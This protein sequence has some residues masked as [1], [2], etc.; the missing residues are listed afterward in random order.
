ML[1]THGWLNI[2]RYT[3]S[4]IPM[5]SQYYKVGTMVGQRTNVTWDILRQSAHKVS[6]GRI[7]AVGISHIFAQKTKKIFFKIFCRKIF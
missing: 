1:G 4:Y 3:A 2:G 6:E 5:L 7:P